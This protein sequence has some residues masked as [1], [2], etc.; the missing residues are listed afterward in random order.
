MHENKK[1]SDHLSHITIIED[2]D[3]TTITQSKVRVATEKSLLLLKVALVLFALGVL[4]HTFFE[5]TLTEVYSE[6]FGELRNS[7][8]QWFYRGEPADVQRELLL[9]D[10]GASLIGLIFRPFELMSAAFAL[11]L[12][13]KLPSGWMAFRNNRSMI[14]RDGRLIWAGENYDLN[15]VSFSSDTK[16]RSSVGHGS[17]NSSGNITI[18]SSGGAFTV[19]TGWLRLEFV[20][21][22]PRQLPLWIG[23]GEEAGPNLRMIQRAAERRRTQLA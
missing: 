10:F 6:Y 23:Q 22:R 20:D 15:N 14:F 7:P 12:P 11:V 1:W 5:E 18:H 21:R 8:N 19:P 4:L 2:E 17:I 13:F 3:A 16:T 9:S